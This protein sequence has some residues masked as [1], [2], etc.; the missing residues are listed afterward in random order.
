M[1][2]RTTYSK[3]MSTGV[4]V[5]VFSHQLNL[6]QWFRLDSYGTVFQAEVLEIK[7]ASAGLPRCCQQLWN[8]QT[9]H[10]YDIEENEEADRLA[11]LGSESPDAT[12]K[13]VPRFMAS[14]Y[15]QIDNS[16]VTDLTVTPRVP[17]G[18]NRTSHVVE[19][20]LNRIEPSCLQR[21]KS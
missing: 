7:K 8:K 4:G 21:P 18:R 6:L 17:S 16:G 2:Q 3:P 19:D 5:G 12:L 10:S 14:A 15:E 20:L 1:G 13:R 11:R 9:S